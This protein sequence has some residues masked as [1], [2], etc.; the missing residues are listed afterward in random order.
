M[1]LFSHPQKCVPA[2]SFKLQSTTCP[3]RFLREWMQQLQR[4]LN[5]HQLVHVTYHTNKLKNKNNMIISTD[6]LKASD[7]NLES[8]HDKNS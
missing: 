6:A 8:I 2:I 5:I 7:K 4:Q 1:L 3:S